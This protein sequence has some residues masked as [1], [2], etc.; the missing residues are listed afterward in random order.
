MAAAGVIASV[1]PSFVPADAAW[2]G[3]R[4]GT[5][6][7]TWAY[8][9]ASMVAAGV[10]LR[11]GSDAPVESPDPFV[12]IRDACTPRFEALS[13][14]QAVDIYSAAKLEIGAPGTFII[15]EDDPIGVPVEEIA[16]IGVR[17]I[18]IEGVDV[19]LP[20]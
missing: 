4:L 1:Q 14:S 11:G 5:H 6:R 9:F 12:G 7:Q 3:R 2:I 16:S 13:P 8:P 15:C 17:A 10:T 20:R 18:W 19:T